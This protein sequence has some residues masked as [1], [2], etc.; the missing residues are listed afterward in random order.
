[1]HVRPLVL[2]FAV[3]SLL[4]ISGAGTIFNPAKALASSS[5]P[6]FNQIASGKISNVGKV[7][8]AGTTFV[9]LN[10]TVQGI[11]V[12]SSNSSH[13]VVSR[14]R[15]VVA[16]AA[17]PV[18]S[19][20][21]DSIVNNPGNATVAKGVNSYENQVVNGVA[22][23]PP[24]QGLCAGNG[25]VID[26]VNT[27]MRIYTTSFTAISGVF[28]PNAIDGLSIAAFTS[29][30]RCLYD[31]AT[32]HWF[33]IQLYIS[34]TGAGQGYEYIAVSATSVPWGR[35]YVYALNVTDS[36]PA[37]AASRYTGQNN[38]PSCPCF[39]DQPL[40]GASRDALAV[41]TNE[42]PIALVPGFNG[43]QVYLLDKFGL[44][45]GAD[46]ISYVHLNALHL[47]TP[48]GGCIASGGVD[49]W[50]S[51]NP[52]ASPTPGQFDNSG[53]G[54]EYA[55]SSL[56][57]SLK[58]DDRLAAWTFTNTRS[59]ASA[60]PDVSFTISL[61]KGLDRY[62]DPLD[63]I[64]NGLLVPQKAGL[65][66]L[67]NTVYSF[68]PY[69]PVFG[70]VGKCKEGMIQSNGDGMFDT[71]V[72]AQG[73]LWGGVN[74][75][76]SEGGKTT[77][78]VYAGVLY[79][80]VSAVDGS[81]FL[82]SQGYVAAKGEDVLFPSIGVGPTGNG[83]LTFTLTGKDYY[84]STAY[85]IVSKTSAGALDR[86]IFVADPGMAPYDA[87]TEYQCIAGTC[88]AGSSYVPR[89]G[90]YTWAVWSD[91][92]V[93]FAT[94][95]IPF[96]SCSNAAFRADSTCDKTRGLDANWG[97]SLNSIAP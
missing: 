58:G 61:A 95:Y 74:T 54:T 3:L 11:P 49:C 66:P 82:A 78:G 71:L 51:I 79:W 59:L 34:S 30:P 55:L 72:Y 60:D 38:D 28:S 94:E 10:P 41:S 25:Y 50:Y 42:F 32:G 87:L 14:A 7:K 5:S 31:Q 92:K 57:F 44:A 73:A 90:D 85:S 48:D 47:Q 27:E 37:K 64:G 39:G 84:P 9:S 26:A 40:L 43:G 4:L 69:S 70:C 8:L 22:F 35:W 65:T 45:A 75:E 68:H 6:A 91:G 52:A 15:P 46:A 23:E 63:A 67:G 16:A 56:D 96:P 21:A 77:T 62:Y 2:S 76:V 93:Y 18:P 81:F 29:D 80:V 19:V 86:K 36:F 53:R 89:W 33:L 12:A 1:M 83:I 97:T 88:P 24:D 13:S 17:S 20:S